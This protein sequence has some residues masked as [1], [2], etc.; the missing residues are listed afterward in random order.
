[1]VGS[2][3]RKLFIGLSLIVIVVLAAFAIIFRDELMVG[4]HK[5]RLLAAKAR[6]WRLTTKGYNAWDH[7][8]EVVRGKPVSA[9]EVVQIWKRHEE[10]LVQFGFLSRK[11]YV[12]AAG[13]LPSRSTSPD[14]NRALA[15][16]EA[17]CPWWSVSR[18][19]TNFVVTA[20]AQGFADWRAVAP[21]AGLRAIEESPANEQKVKTR[22][23]RKR[24]NARTDTLTGKLPA[25]L[26]LPALD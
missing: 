15:R 25:G 23:W 19:G 13:V 10:A 4:Y 22:C 9:D 5:N 12:A 8:V 26:H 11:T 7:V 2:R 3:K 17:S 14:Y 20:C 24:K 18:V 1:M 16:M 6:H 21:G